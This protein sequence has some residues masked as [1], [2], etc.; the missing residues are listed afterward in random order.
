MSRI[1]R[2]QVDL[3]GFL[4]LADAKIRTPATAYRD[5]K[6]LN[7]FL[8][9]LKQRTPD[10]LATHG[11]PT[12]P[13]ESRCG[14]ELNLIVSQDSPIVFQHLLDEGSKD[15]KLGWAGSLTTKF[16]PDRIYCNHETGRL[17]HPMPETHRS[18]LAPWQKDGSGLGLLRSAMIQMHLA[19][20]LDEDSIVW[21]GVRY[22]LTFCK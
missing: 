18:V 5:Q 9:H 22:P 16:Y 11:D 3:Q 13:Y 15:C 20:K 14:K 10:S 8:T 6:F 7:F 17:Y 1:Y 12:F 4:Y 2:Y 19:D 21:K